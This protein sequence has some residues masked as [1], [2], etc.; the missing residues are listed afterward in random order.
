MQRTNTL[1]I[2][3]LFVLV[4]QAQTHFYI[5]QIAV[6]P[7]NP[8]TSDNVSISLIGN[9]SDGGAYIATAVAEVSGNDVNITLVAMSNGGITVLIPHTEV[10]QLGQLPAG[11]YIIDFTD[12]S[13]GILDSAPPPQHMFTVSDGG[14]VGTCADL[15]LVSV[16]W[17]AFNDTVLMVLVANPTFA[18]FDYPNFILFDSSGD[19]LAIET[20]NPFA[21]T[22]QSW[23]VLRVMDGVVMP[24]APFEGR[25]E[26][27]TGF[28]DSL[29]CTWEQ[30][31]DLCPPAPCAELSPTVANSGGPPITG[32][33]N[34]Q[35]YDD[36]G[37]IA[38]GVFELTPDAQQADTSICLPPGNYHL[39]VSP[40]D[41]FFMGVLYYNLNAPGWQ[42]T[43]SLIVSVSLP[44]LLP[45]TFYGPCIS[46]TQSLGEH[47]LPALITAPTYGG[48]WVQHPDGLPLGPLW[49]FDMQGR[50]IFN[51]T[52]STD[53]LFVPTP[54]PGV[55]VLR[56][57][58]RTVKVPGGVE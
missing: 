26:L 39:N 21:I 27:W 22:D 46:G 55:Y 51:T 38:N 37:I 16:H 2:S 58:A 13:T 35:L 23:H 11:D 57:G 32:Q 42:Y 17:H 1:F 40:V 36:M 5:D 8:T 30:T 18:P 28:T 10:L 6:S 14:G 29:A 31:F 25:L 7:P 24:P 9:L 34:W 56:A 43:P 50:L 45:F 44:V 48:I 47:T 12:A 33:F 19:T 54:A 3:C 53:R 52:A 49:L 15:E 41:P 4:A 20:V